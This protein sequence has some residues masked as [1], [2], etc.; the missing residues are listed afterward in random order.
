MHTAII[1]N[2]F[3]DSP[4]SI[5]I[6]QLTRILIAKSAIQQKLQHKRMKNGNVFACFCFFFFCFFGRHHPAK[7]LGEKKSCLWDCYCR[8]YNNLSHSFP[9]L[10]ATPGAICNIRYTSYINRDART[11]N[12]DLNAVVIPLIWAMSRL[13]LVPV[14]L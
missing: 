7:V 8:W 4:A 6:I 11:P 2:H 14:L 5:C 3:G 1:L 13:H 12:R 10:L 9:Q